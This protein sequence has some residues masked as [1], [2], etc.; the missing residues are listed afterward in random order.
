MHSADRVETRETDERLRQLQ[1]AARALRQAESTAQWTQILAD[2]A[3]RF[4]SVVLFCRV[5]SGS[6]F[7]DAARGAAQPAEAIP[8]AG[9]FR[10]AV[11]TKE[12]VVA[13]HTP[14]EI[15]DMVIDAIAAPARRAYL[16]PLVGKTRVLGVLLAEG[17]P[18]VHALELLMTIAA[19]T[20]E[21]REVRPATPLIAP[22]PRAEHTETRK[23]LVTAAKSIL[24]AGSVK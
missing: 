11:D 15:S 19:A 21:L 24:A 13:L 22:A 23:D 10:Q 6:L 2:T 3:A 17:L 9:A 14:S 7:C 16:F 5:D 1:Q 4:A 18:D 8:L 20:L 12:N